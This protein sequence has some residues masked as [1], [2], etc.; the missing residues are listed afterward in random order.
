MYI[1]I[2][3]YTYICTSRSLR[4]PPSRGASRPIRCGE[5]EGEGERDRERG[6]GWLVSV[7]V[8]ESRALLGVGMGDEALSSSTSHQK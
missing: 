2:H 3:L 1:H 7:C 8:R 4:A 5:R 6:G